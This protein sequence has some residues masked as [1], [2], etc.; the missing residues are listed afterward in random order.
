MNGSDCKFMKMPKGCKFTH[1]PVAVAAPL[2]T[3]DALGAQ[4]YSE[5]VSALNQANCTEECHARNVGGRMTGVFLDC[6]SPDELSNL[7]T[8]PTEFATYMMSAF[9]IFESND[10]TTYIRG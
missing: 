1:A 8:K 3:R 4:V 2:T 6:F 10:K 9:E 5:I 7:L